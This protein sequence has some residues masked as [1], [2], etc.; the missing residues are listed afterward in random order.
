MRVALLAHGELEARILPVL[1]EPPVRLEPEVVVVAEIATPSR[2]IARLRDAT[3]RFPD[4]TMV[5]VTGEW[6]GGAIRRIL[7][8]GV[9]G[10]VLLDEVASALPSAIEATAAGSLVLPRRLRDDAF[11]PALSFREKQVLGL[12]VLGL[13]NAEISVKLYLTE[14]TVKSHLS[15]AYRKLG[16]A[17]RGEATARILD[18][19]E[20]YGLGI[21]AISQT[22]HPLGPKPRAVR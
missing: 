1:A 5:L 22:T 4:A 19:E 8:T 16:V 15:S 13:T 14:S 17:S 7:A 6:H 2:A 12:V 9:S 11:V 3:K 18:E 21:L 10:L 20:G